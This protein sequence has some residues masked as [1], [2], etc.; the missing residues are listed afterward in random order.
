M[1]RFIKNDYIINI[2][3]IVTYI[4]SLKIG[5]FFAIPPGNVTPIF[6][7]AGVAMAALLL[8]GYKLL[9]GVWLGSFLGN[10]LIS[11]SYD[12]TSIFFLSASIA[13]GSTL[14]A[15]FGSFIVK[16]VTKT[17]NPFSKPINVIL[18][19]VLGAFFACILGSV[20]GVGS[21]YLVGIIASNK[22]VYTWFT[23]YLGD[24]MGVITIVPFIMVWQ[25]KAIINF[26][27]KTFLEI[28]GLAFI[29]VIGG[30]FFFK[31]SYPL[32]FLFII[33]QMV[34]SLR[35]MQYGAAVFSVLI[36]SLLMYASLTSLP[37][38]NYFSL[39]EKLLILQSF[40]GVTSTTMMVLA[41]LVF[42]QKKAQLEIIELA[43][44]KRIE[45]LINQHMEFTNTVLNSLPGIFFM[46]DKEENI[47]KWNDNFERVSGYEAMEIFGMNPSDFFIEKNIFKMAILE[48]F[49]TGNSFFEAKFISK[50]GESILFYFTG[51]RVF[52]EN[53]PCLIGIGIDISERKKAQEEL[54]KSHKEL[55][56]AKKK[57]EVAN[58]AK[59][60]FLANMSHEIRTPMNAILGYTQILKR[61]KS[62]VPEV[63]DMIQS[64]YK[65]GEHLLG[66]INDILDISKIEAGKIKLL[67][68]SFDLHYMFDDLQKMFQVHIMNKSLSFEL[69]IS[70]SLPKIIKADQSRLRQIFINLLSNAIKFTNE[71][72]IKLSADIQGNKIYCTIS[73]TG[74]GIPED[75]L[76]M[77]FGTFEQTEI[78]MRASGGTG[79][80]LTISKKLA[81]LMKGDVTVESI[82]GKGSSF[83][84][85]FEFEEGDESVVRQI[86]H[87]NRILKL[88]DNQ[89]EKRVLVV[90]D[91]ALNRDVVIKLLHLIGFSTREA[92]NGKQAVEIFQD[93]EP[94]VVLMDIVMPVMDGVEA[95]QKIRG[96]KTGRTACIIGLSA[97][98]F[99]NS[100]E[101]ILEQG[102]N[103]F[104]K[105]P[106]KENELLETIKYYTGI[107]YV[108]EGYMES[109]EEVEVTN[110]YEINLTAL[111]NDIKDKLSQAAI[112][113]DLDILEALVKEVEKFDEQVAKSLKKLIADF[114]LSKIQEI[115]VI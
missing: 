90:D 108:Y 94:H 103:T 70:E 73:D 8:R 91:N 98:T 85:S 38:F 55:M 5:M 65:S 89:G 47:L 36:S 92:E 15:L 114:N 52:I 33:F 75:K 51:V 69:N 32:Y 6:P 83:I 60:E 13:C 20:W 86:N 40:I 64:I 23:W 78:G 109:I 9:I 45:S 11:T 44:Q 26:N 28:F 74:I 16:R 37:I 61:D 96:L 7:P 46:F 2:I 76:D 110:N 97:S 12:N 10:I 31:S 29:T 99:Y 39:N 71:G 25:I 19:I 82:I 68:E 63:Q 81:R 48:V 42:Q 100:H 14:Q 59:S 106:F 27:T 112:N 35:F 104:M 62:I 66:L 54:L 21:M 41:T 87:K 72:S 49:A 43:E 84:V 115:F 88:K 105:K 101:K 3:V 95:T 34:A 113:G 57:A 24:A 77:I 22:I 50:N 17:N 111:P 79:L 30:L 80:G 53:K 102:A 1:N 93:W 4:I 107:E 18:F 58:K 67:P 56:Q